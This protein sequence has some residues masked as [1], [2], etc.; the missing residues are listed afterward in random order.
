MM[1]CSQRCFV[2]TVR[3]TFTAS[4]LQLV[5]LYTYFRCSDVELQNE[6]CQLLLWHANERAAITNP[7]HDLW[8]E[9]IRV[10]A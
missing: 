5:S 9:V 3:R 7:S 2:P 10:R 6:L 1:S 4:A 8:T